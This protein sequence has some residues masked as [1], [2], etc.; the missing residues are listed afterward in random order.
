MRKEFLLTPG[1]SQVPPEVL[2]DL[3]KP[4]Y[5]H[6]T[7]RFQAVYAETLGDRKSVV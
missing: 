7:K 5:H 4:V 1:P 6:R 3:A 2:L